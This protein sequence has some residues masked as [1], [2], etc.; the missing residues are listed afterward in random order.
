MDRSVGPCVDFYNIPVAA[1]ARKIPFHPTG[2]RDGLLQS[3]RRQS[4]FSPQILQQAAGASQRDAVTQKVGDFYAACM[5]ESA[6]NKRGL[7]AIKSEWMTLLRS[8]HSMICSDYGRL[9]LGIVG[10]SMIFGSG[11][12]QIQT[13]QR[14]RLRTWTKRDRPS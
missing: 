7:S 14:N 4:E 13:I 9:Q 10:N 5:D 12:E 3:L 8:N 1:G 11:S 6:V 2:L